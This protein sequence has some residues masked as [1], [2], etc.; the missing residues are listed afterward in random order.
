MLRTRAAA[1]NIASVTRFAPDAMT[2]RPTPGKMNEL[3]HCP[4]VT[5]PRLVGTGA[6][7]LPVATNARSSVHLRRSLGV[8][9]HFEVGFDN[10]KMIGRSTCFAISRTISSV[11]APGWAEVPIRIVG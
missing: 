2:P 6:K 9:S 4:M 11:N 1:T 3:L 5:G 7:G 10:G 8:A